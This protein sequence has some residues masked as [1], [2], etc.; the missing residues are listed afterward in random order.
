MLDQI[1][2]F[3]GVMLLLQLSYH[4]QMRAKQRGISRECVMLVSRHADRHPWVPGGACALSIS[5]RARHRLIACGWPPAQVER[6]QGVVVIAD[7]T[8]AK[9]ITV[10]HSLGRKRRL[11]P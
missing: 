10:E 9:I 8:A 11:R 6:T 3:G 5:D 4:A 2:A 1:P 7:L